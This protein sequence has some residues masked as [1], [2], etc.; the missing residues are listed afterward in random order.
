MALTSLVVCADASAVQV[1]SRILSDL[2]IEVE[3]SNES[4]AALARLNAQAFDAV[5]IDCQDEAAA[6]DL[7]TR[8]Q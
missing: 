8:C 4:S 1:L 3:Q 2:G 7:I 6:L 5:L